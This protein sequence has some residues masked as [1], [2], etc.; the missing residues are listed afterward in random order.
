LRFAFIVA[1]LVGLGLVWQ[2][3]TKSISSIVQ[4]LRPLVVASPAVSA[5]TEF[6]CPMD[7]G[8]VSSWPA[9][10]PICNMD[11]IPRK[12]SDGVLL[13]AGVVGR[14]QIAPYRIQLAG[15][16]TVPIELRNDSITFAD[17]ATSHD[18]AT[19]SSDS[20]ETPAD[21]PSPANAEIDAWVPRT[22]IVRRGAE[23][24]VF[25]QTMP[26]MFEAV[27]VTIGETQGDRQSVRGKLAVGQHVVSEGAYLLDAE[28]RLHPHL[29]TQYFGANRDAE[30]SQPPR[31]VRESSRQTDE[32]WRTEL[33]EDDRQLVDRQQICPVTEFPL[34]SMGKPLF[35]AVAGRR[36]AICCA[37]CQKRL[38]QTPEK[39]FQLL[40]ARSTSSTAQ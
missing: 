15:T 24:L 13:P 36:V 14:M 25:V 18:P 22:S 37:G 8:V 3:L 2:S 39:Y 4:W 10:C 16:R 35:V 5:D 11:L 7:P 38:E 29:S 27:A 20:R 19:V 6:F 9:I 33:T 12:T 1:A 32:T 21:G 34:G 40:D 17:P 23:S 30:S 26:D 28:D 31:V